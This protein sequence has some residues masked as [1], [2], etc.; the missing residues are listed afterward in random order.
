MFACV[1]LSRLMAVIFML[2]AD[3]LFH[4]VILPLF[5]DMLWSGSAFTWLSVSAA[6]GNTGNL[7]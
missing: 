5:I 4:L 6:A 2:L 1:R 3:I 7:L